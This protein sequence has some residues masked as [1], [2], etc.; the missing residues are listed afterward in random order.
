MLSVHSD[1]LPVVEQGGFYVARTPTHPDFRF[2]LCYAL[3]VYSSIFNLDLFQQ[4]YPFCDFFKLMQL[5][6]N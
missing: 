5:C 2:K 1:T 6:L 3:I 4:I